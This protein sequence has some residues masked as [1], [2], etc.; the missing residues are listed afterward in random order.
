MPVAL[1]AAWRKAV[2]MSP[3]QIDH[4][5]QSAMQRMMRRILNKGVDA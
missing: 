1:M 4:P 3:T 5:R 2:L